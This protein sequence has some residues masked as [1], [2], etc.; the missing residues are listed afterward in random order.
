[1]KIQTIIKNRE[2]QMEF[3]R[4]Q[5]YL[6]PVK[7]TNLNVDEQIVHDAISYIE[8]NIDNIKLDVVHLSEAMYQS[9]S[10][11]YRKVKLVT[12]KSLV[13]LIRD[14]R[15]KHAASL[16]KERKLT[17]TEVAYKSG[18]SS[19]KYFRKCFKKQYAVN[20]SE[21]HTIDI[22]NSSNLSEEQVKYN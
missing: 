21:F 20:P 5:M 12:G 8:N 3:Y 4:R 7:E 14:V 17:V 9:R 2:L 11:L 1:M 19:I 18:F 10:N 22:G 13:E 6:L 15:L 16:L